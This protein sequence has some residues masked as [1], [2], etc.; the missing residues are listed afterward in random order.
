MKYDTVLFD[1]DGTLLDTVDDLTDSV[2]EVL[3]A[4]GYPLRTRDEVRLA[5]GNGARY[6]FRKVLPE[7]VSDSAMDDIMAQYKIIY[8]K[9]MR[10][11]T[12]PYDG[13]MDMLGELKT[14][15]VKTA[16]ISN[17]P[18]YAVGSLCRDYFGEHID[19]AV[20]D[21]P[22]VARKPEPESGEI[23]M[24]KLGSEKEKTLY[25]GDSDVDIIMGRNLG[26]K[27]VGV[28]WGFRDVDSLKKEGADYII[29][30][31]GELVDIVKGSVE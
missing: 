6:L 24:Q 14:L 3:E 25:V 18:D 5:T 28:P 2:N 26:V 10:N 16:V 12:K 4:N 1:L 11:K 17:K 19:I 27:S 30:E 21:R 15:G 9:N 31:P 7:G 13:I 20:G 22:D 23:V 8:K 29:N